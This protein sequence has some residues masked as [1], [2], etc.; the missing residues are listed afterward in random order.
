MDRIQIEQTVL[1]VLVTMLKQKFDSSSDITRKHVANWD[2]LKHIE[3]MFAL[4][5][6]LGVVFSEEEL[7]DLDGFQKIVE[8]VWRRKN[9]A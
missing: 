3:I 5:D 7:A 4:E 2:S 1:A 8:A 9:A 6:E